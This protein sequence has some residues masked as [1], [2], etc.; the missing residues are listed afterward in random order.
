MIEENALTVELL[1][2]YLCGWR[3]NLVAVCMRIP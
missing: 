3:R 2:V 1:V